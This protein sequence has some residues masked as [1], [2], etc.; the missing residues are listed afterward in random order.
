[1]ELHKDIV[2]VVLKKSQD[3]A[4]SGVI[5]LD[6]LWE[7]LHPPSTWRVIPGFS[8]H[9]VLYFL[10]TDLPLPATKEELYH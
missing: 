8:L 1:M 5:Y 7:L 3:R 9:A 10:Y 4:E 2:L 6:D